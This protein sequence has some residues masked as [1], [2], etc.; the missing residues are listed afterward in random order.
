MDSETSTSTSDSDDLTGTPE[1]AI[2]TFKYEPL[3]S[4]I[5]T[6]RRIALQ[7]PVDGEDKAII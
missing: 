5:D 1:E 7:P 4:S 3:D 2:S 6:I